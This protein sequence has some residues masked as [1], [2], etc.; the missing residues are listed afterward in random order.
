MQEIPTAFSHSCSSRCHGPEVMKK[1]H[2]DEI[3]PIYNVEM[4][5]I[6]DILTFIGRINT[7]S[8]SFKARKV[9]I[10]QHF[11]FLGTRNI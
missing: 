3:Y 9:Y 11:V 5:T 4:P 10:F 7:A 2:E 8:K 6:V 1:F